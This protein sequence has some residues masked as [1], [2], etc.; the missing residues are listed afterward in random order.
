MMARPVSESKARLSHHAEG[1]QGP[2]TQ[3]QYDP[4]V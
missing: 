1:R 4:V 2:I 3:V